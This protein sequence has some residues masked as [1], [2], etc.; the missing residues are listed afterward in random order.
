MFKKI[1]RAI[2]A[3]KNPFKIYFLDFWYEKSENDGL[4][5]LLF[6]FG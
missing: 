4:R 5:A 1:F 2:S 6:G 3:F